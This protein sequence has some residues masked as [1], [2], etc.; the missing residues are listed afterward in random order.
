M[1]GAVQLFSAAGD[2]ISLILPTPF[3]HE[4][5]EAQIQSWADLN[6]ALVN[7]G[8]PMI[9]LGREILTKYSRAIDNLFIDGDGVLVVVEM[10]RGKAT[11]E[12]LAQTFEYAAFADCLNW[13]DVDRLCLKRHSS[14]LATIFATTFGKAINKGSKPVHR[15]AIVAEVF[16]PEIIDTAAYHINRG[17]QLALIE[18]QLFKVGAESLLQ[19]R[20]VLEVPRQSGA[21]TSAEANGEPSDGYASWLLSSVGEM[22]PQIATEQGWSVRR[23]INLQSLPFGSVEWP[24][25]LGDCQFRLDVFKSNFVSLRFAFRQA[26]APGLRD[27]LEKR[28][29]DWHLAFPAKFDHADPTASYLT[30]TLDLP[31]PELGNRVQLENILSELKRMTDALRPVIDSYFST[32]SAT[33]D[34]QEEE[35]SAAVSGEMFSII[36]GKR[37]DAHLHDPILA[38]GDHEAALSVGRQAA[39]RLGVSD[40]DIAKLYA[41]QGDAATP[42][43]NG[44]PSTTVSKA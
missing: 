23:R 44:D 4:H 15:L 37:E 33:K 35:P 22:L 9:S 41:P 34:A 43:M 6:P 16:G 42:E 14:D 30:F 11:R 3:A 40:A 17:I 19:M 38:A 7:E 36:D 5:L 29:Q 20:T 13:E 1:E 18:F 12:V 28:K 10:K 8:Q 31:R 24:L 32:N 26:R 2:A 27:F 25:A 21:T 39:R